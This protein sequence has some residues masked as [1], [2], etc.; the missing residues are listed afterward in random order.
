VFVFRT[1]IEAYVTL[2]TRSINTSVFQRNYNDE[3]SQQHTRFASA[4]SVQL[5]IRVM[6]SDMHTA[7]NIRQISAQGGTLWYTAGHR[8]WRTRLPYHVD[9]AD[10]DG[11]KL[12]N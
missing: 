11:I 9:K 5:Q 8:K 4:I 1:Q 2:I 6:N 7:D 12:W 3:S 10:I